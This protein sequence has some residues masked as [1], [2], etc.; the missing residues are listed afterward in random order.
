MDYNSLSYIK[1]ESKYHVVFISKYRKKKMYEAIR[2]ELGGE[3][4]RLAE[5][6]EGKILE[7][8]LMSDHIHMPIEILPKYSVVQVIGYMKGKSAICVARKHGE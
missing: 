7:G 4:R 8:H 3:L 2:K 5:Q 6:K 1:W